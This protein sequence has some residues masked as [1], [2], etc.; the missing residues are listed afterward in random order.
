MCIRAC[1]PGR[2]V[3]SKVALKW[4]SLL[5]STKQQARVRMRFKEIRFQRDKY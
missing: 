4:V 1:E 5:V 3:L 2:N